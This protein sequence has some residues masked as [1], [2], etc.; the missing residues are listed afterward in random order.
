[1]GLDMY[2]HGEKFFWTDWD[3][4]ENTRMEDGI[5]VS[6]LEV[7]LGY[8]RKHPDLHG[9]IVQTFAEGK[10]ECQRIPLDEKQL[11]QTLDAVLAEALPHTEGFFFG[12]SQ[13]SDK[14]DSL[15]QLKAA[16]EWLMTE[17][18]KGVS[19]SVYYR[20]SW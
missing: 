11:R 15:K 4:P 14:G 16:I 12:Q 10:D 2:L 1:M 9:F 3:H 7:E 18:K 5:K 20:A 6:S 8:W 19:R 13:S 17:E